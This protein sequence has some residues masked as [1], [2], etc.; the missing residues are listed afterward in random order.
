MR[1]A[2]RG[3]TSLQSL[4]GAEGLRSDLR[5]HVCSCR[6]R[7]DGWM[8]VATRKFKPCRLRVENSALTRSVSP[9]T[10]SRQHQK[11]SALV[12]LLVLRLLPEEWRPSLA[13]QPA[14]Q[15]TKPPPRPT[16]D[17]D[18]SVQAALDLS[19]ACL[20]PRRSS[21]LVPILG[22]LI[23]VRRSTFE[24]ALQI[25]RSVPPGAPPC[26]ADPIPSGHLHLPPE[27]FVAET[28]CLCERGQPPQ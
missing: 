5:A 22:A 19:F 24:L 14:C 18:G 23:D 21:N 2:P 15:R 20:G 27:C 26:C 28:S 17:K 7:L 10:P 6:P 4:C 11:R 3:L 13:S 25:D 9:D 8:G 1:A 16:A 12:P